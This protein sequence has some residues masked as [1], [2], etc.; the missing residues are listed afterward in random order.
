MKPDLCI[1]RDAA[2]LAGAAAAHIAETLARVATPSLVL[3][4]GTTPR[5]IYEQLAAPP[6]RER[7][8]WSS[9]RVFWGD[10]RCVGPEDGRSNYRMA[11]EALLRHVPAGAVHRI[12][13]ELG[14]NQAAEQYEE[15]I[16]QAFSLKPGQWPRFSLVLLG[17]G[18]DGHT[19]SLFPGTDVL[20]VEDRIVAG[21]YVPQ[22]GVH[23]VTLT[24]PALAHAAEIM[25]VVTGTAK[26]TIV[27]EV[28]TGDGKRFPI[29]HVTPVSGRLRWYLD[30]DAA[31]LLPE[32]MT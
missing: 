7:I 9:L 1:H 22:L 20:E 15:A 21:V 8:A 4:G 28:L 16:R 25:V 6:Q 23:R 18:E 14:P 29:G 30:A 31:S 26:A 17:L 3:A 2:S 24:L 27:R 12:E 10:E 32:G 19:A 11:R 5:K 13:A